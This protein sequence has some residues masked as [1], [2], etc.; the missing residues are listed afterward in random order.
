[1]TLVLVL[2]LWCEYDTWREIHPFKVMKEGFGKDQEE[3][4]LFQQQTSKL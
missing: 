4:K 3:N 1:M 2:E